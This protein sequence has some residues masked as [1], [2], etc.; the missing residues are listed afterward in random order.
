MAKYGD[1]AVLATN[2]VHAAK[3]TSPEEAWKLAAT[4]I[5]PD[6]VPSQKKGCP[7]GAFLGLCEE[8]MV[9]GI[10]AGSYST[11]VHNKKYALRALSLLRSEPSF[12]G[13]AK[14]L[15]DRVMD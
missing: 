15:W 14:A 5:F 2:I 11:S 7:K 4:E 8:G 6:K 9:K 12:S 13:G 1:T 10:S 3:V